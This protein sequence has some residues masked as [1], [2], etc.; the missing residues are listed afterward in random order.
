MNSITEL[1]TLMKIVEDGNLSVQAKINSNDEFQKL[2]NCFNSMITKLKLNYEELSALYEQI[3]ATEGELRAQYDELQYSQRI[4]RKGEER[5]RLALDGS[6]DAIWEFDLESYEF[7]VSDKFYEM[8]GYT[9][10]NKHK[11]KYLFNN[12]THPHDKTKAKKALLDHINNNTPLYQSEFRIKKGNNSYMW[13]FN[14]GKALRDETGKAVKLAGSITDITDRKLTEKKILYMAHYDAL[15]CLPNRTYFMNKLYDRLK[16]AEISKAKGAILFIDLDN[17]KII[18]D[19][20]GHDY[21]DLL[22]KHISSKLLKMLKKSDIICRLG[23][24]EFVI[25]HPYDKEDEVIFLANQIIHMF[26]NIFEIGDKQMSITASLGI[27]IYPKDGND[28]NSILKNSD[29]AMYKA[30]ELGKN[31]YAFL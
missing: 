28:V 24:D 30:K 26:S 22:L 25:L 3:S 31:R 5:Y 20:M 29:A 2:G 17:F 16:T 23:G 15:T 1:T 21:G 27:S 6:N 9:R 13:I 8:T 4:L 12:L 7:F 11:I 14:R 19:T 18:N 10:N